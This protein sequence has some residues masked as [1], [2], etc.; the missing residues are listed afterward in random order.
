MLN[1]NYNWPKKT[2]KINHKRTIPSEYGQQR[3]KSTQS[4]ISHLSHIH[5]YK[6]YI[7]ETFLY[8]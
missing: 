3:Q 2:T 1:Q 4:L 8:T 5:P 7:T 6:Y